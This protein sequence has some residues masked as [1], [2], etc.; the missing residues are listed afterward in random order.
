MKKLLIVLIFFI[1][2]VSGC[3]QKV[4]REQC[5]NRNIIKS[6]EFEENGVTITGSGSGLV[7]DTKSDNMIEIGESVVFYETEECSHI[8]TLKEFTENGALIE[9]RSGCAESV[10]RVCQF[11]VSK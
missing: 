1:I 10:S 2:L 6:V 11:E 8:F 9:Y 4:S 3:I 7:Q 5:D